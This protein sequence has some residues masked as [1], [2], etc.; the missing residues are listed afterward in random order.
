[1]SEYKIAIKIMGELDGSFNSAI[2]GAQAGIRSLGGMRTAGAVAAGIGKGIVAS[3]AIAGK[4]LGVTTAALVGVGAASV[5]VGKEF[6]SSMASLAATA[7]V[8]K[9]SAEFGKLKDAALEMG[10]STSKT[11]S[12]C[13]QALEYMALAGWDVDDAITGLPSIVHASEAFGTGLKE[14]S[15]LIT[16]SMSAAGVSI[17]QLPN[18]LDVAARAQTS[19][20]MSAEQMMEAF[21]DV[22]GVMRGLGVPITDT[23]TALGVLAN[24]GIKG[25]EAGTALKAIM[26]NLTTGTGQAGEMMEKLGVSAFDA[27][28]NFIGLEGT[29]QNL[30]SALQDLTPEERNAALQAIGGKQHVDALTDLLAGLN[31]T[32]KDG[33]SVW[34]ALSNKLENAK[35]AF[36]ELYARKTDTLEYDLK[37][38]ASAAQNAGIQIFEAMKQGEGGLRSI[39]QT[40]TEQINRLSAALEEGGFG[41]MAYEVG[42]V[43]ADTLEQVTAAIPEMQAAASEL[44]GSLLKGIQD[45]ADSIG[46]SV[47]QLASAGI[48]GF[49]SWYGDFWST[50]LSLAEGFLKGFESEVPN[51]S[52]S[53]GTMIDTLQT[54]V[55][56]NLPGIMDAGAG[57]LTGLMDGITNNTDGTLDL[58]SSIITHISEGFK[59]HA[60]EIGASAV[61][62][63]GAIGNGF[64]EHAGEFASAGLNIV[65]GIA[66]AISDNLGEL[67][68]SSTDIVNKLAEGLENALSDGSEFVSRA[69]AIVTKI[70]TAIQENGPELISAGIKLLGELAKGLLQGISLVVSAI[71]SILDTMFNTFLSVD[72]FGLGCQLMSNI[73]DGLKSLGAAAVGAVQE[74]VNNILHAG[75]GTAENQAYMS[76][77]ISN[78]QQTND[79]LYTKDNVNYLTAEDIAAGKG[80]DTEEVMREAQGVVDAYKELGAS[81]A[82]EYNKAFSEEMKKSSS[83]TAAEST[84]AARKACEE[85]NK[86]FLEESTKSA[87]EAGKA[88]TEGVANGIDENSDAIKGAAETSATGAT[89]A[90]AKAVEEGSTLIDQQVAEMTQGLTE[91]TQTA[92]EAVQS[93]ADDINAAIENGTAT[94]DSATMGAVQSASEAY[95][96]LSSDMTQTSTDITTAFTDLGTQIST[97]TTDIGTAFTD[98]STTITTAQTSITTALTDIGTQITTLSTTIST[99]LLSVGAQIGV[100]SALI[101]AMVSAG[102]TTISTTI[103]TAITTMATSMSTSLTTIITILSTS[104]MTLTMMIST[105]LTTI[106]TTISTSLV[107]VITLVSTSMTG[108]TTAISSGMT[109][110]VAAVTAGMSQLVAAIQSYG[111]QAISTA[112]SIAQGIQQAFASVDLSSAGAQMMQGLINGMESMRAAVISTAQSIASAAASAVNGALQVASPSRLMISTG[113]FTGEG[114]AIGMEN[115]TRQ[116]QMAAQQMTDPIRGQTMTPE[117]TRSGIL[118]ETL[119]NLSGGSSQ[120]GGNVQQTSSPTF[121]FSPTYVIEGN[122]DQ[123]T[124]QEA[125]SMSQREFEKMA[126]EWVRQSGR[127]AFA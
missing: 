70:G 81:T 20:N 11:A 14:T 26:A 19:S 96:Q 35:G 91:A 55:D 97:A 60:S 100:G 101:V 16:D 74:I 31:D 5:K 84:E 32:T 117:D 80:F 109:A 42:G 108:I 39:A 88:M 69:K 122:A 45:N 62:L 93:G 51:L 3:A 52:T 111:Q 120:G 92:S 29:L 36:D 10:R 77:D 54:S 102:V 40:G 127:T 86:A 58:A 25:S 99:T 59:E 9:T 114:L 94:A 67:A 56:D 46:G 28:G 21:L 61:D 2:A 38:L 23:A 47:A 50:G 103:S 71:P 79:G 72:W 105:N 82:E 95:Q 104:I 83:D 75:E 22:G 13:A 124:L 18:Y 53:F 73:I 30:N 90:C 27:D 121:N 78:Y 8:E 107:S 118:G 113:E 65:E 64:V 41:A 43:I 116:V 12:E 85:S 87:E 7:G 98:M 1:M 34:D 44:Y 33:V 112:T 115:S 126:N 66:T 15:D 6:E 106:I 89:E 110:A 4:A 119:G 17:E 125:N 24:Q 37:E 49:M 68:Q 48:Q 123:A 57:I 63:I 76:R